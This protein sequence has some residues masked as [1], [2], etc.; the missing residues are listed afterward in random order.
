MVHA[1]TGVLWFF[2]TQNV[3]QPASRRTVAIVAFAR[4]MWEL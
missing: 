1:S 2:P 3:L 4:G